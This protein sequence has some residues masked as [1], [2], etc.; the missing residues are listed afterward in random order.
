MRMLK[1]LARGLDLLRG[2]VAWPMR[3]SE[4]QLDGSDWALAEKQD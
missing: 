4:L 2:D 1:L 3:L